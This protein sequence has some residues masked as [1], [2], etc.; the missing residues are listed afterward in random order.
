MT[1]DLNKLDLIITHEGKGFHRI[2]SIS[3]TQY[4]NVVTQ[5]RSVEQAKHRLREALE[6]YLDE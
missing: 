5:G 1:Q 2:F 6:L 3:S 4:P